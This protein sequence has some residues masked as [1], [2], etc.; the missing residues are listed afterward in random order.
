MF[1][2]TV[3]YITIYTNANNLYTIDETQ[4]YLLFNVCAYYH[5]YFK[6]VI[7]SSFYM[8]F[9]HTSRIKM[10]TIIDKLFFI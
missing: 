10:I 9:I 5:Y 8:Q 1:L 7:W 3:F 2:F 6:F 4:I